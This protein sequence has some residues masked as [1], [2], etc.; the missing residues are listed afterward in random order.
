MTKEVI[1]YDKEKNTF[2]V[3]ILSEKPYL[4]YQKYFLT[5]YAVI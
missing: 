4:E 5:G 3:K 1:K 2:F